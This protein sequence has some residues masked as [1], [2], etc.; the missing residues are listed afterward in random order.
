[1]SM[2]CGWKEQPQFWV[3]LPKQAE[4]CRTQALSSLGYDNMIFP[5]FPLTPRFGVLEP[6]L[7]PLPLP[8]SG[9]LQSWALGWVNPL[10]A[11]R[12][13]G[14]LGAD[15]GWGRSGRGGGQ[16]AC[17]VVM[18]AGWAGASLMLTG[19]R[20]Q[21]VF[22][23]ERNFQGVALPQLP[24]PLHI[25]PAGLSFLIK[26]RAAAMGK[27]MGSRGDGSWERW[28]VFWAL[29]SSGGHLV[30]FPSPPI[31][32]HLQLCPLPLFCALP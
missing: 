24:R 18:D 10:S 14:A 1:M 5:H 25:G 19:A 20:K 6:F 8:C 28:P 22:Q 32:D 11:V 4:G 2:Q 13:I 29:T 31:S 17:Q 15:R 26:L 12:G 30:L 23:P 3:L 7:F 9:P 16:A 27:G 21:M